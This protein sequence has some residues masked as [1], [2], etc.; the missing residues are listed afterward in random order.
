MSTTRRQF[1]KQSAGAVTLSLVMPRTLFARA[2]DPDRRVLVVIELAGGNDGF[3][4][5]VPYTD[6]RYFSLRPTLSLKDSDLRDAQGRSTII[7][8]RLGFHPSMGKL[9]EMHDAGRVATVVGVGYP[10]PNGSHFVSADIWH[11]AN[12]QGGGGAEGWLGRYADFALVGRSGLGAIAVE[13]RLPKT[14]ASSQVVVPSTPNFDEYGL[15]T[16]PDYPRNRNVK[17]NT[18]LSLHNRA[19]PAGSFVGQE[20]RIGFDAVN[21]ALQFREALASYRTTVNYPENNSLADGLQLLAQ[22]I[23]SIP[24]VSLLYVQMGGFDHHS[25]QVASADNR[26]AGQHAGLL[27]DFSDGV[28][29]FYRDLAQHG[30]ADNVLMLQ[31]S[32]F[33]RRP[34]ENKSLGT[35]HGA[36]SSIFVIGN[37]VK[38]GIYG[39]QPSLAV[40]DLDDSGNAKFNVDF[41]SVYATILDGWLGGDSKSVL[42]GQFE[43]MGFL[44]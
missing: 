24:T 17:I 41:R 11:T 27:Q 28:E 40:A 29:A 10:N 36:A 42:G 39:R 26:R 23:S 14:L 15:Q 7:S 3:N 44:A 31:W 37:K 2:A 34:E 1:I 32:E 25:N 5:V 9:K 38:G 35:D 21:G 16:D 19:F 12:P 43:N 22:V 20:A 4:T 8:D 6:S 13:D 30:L 18:L 33:G